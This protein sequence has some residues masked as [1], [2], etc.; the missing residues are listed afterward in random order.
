MK[1]IEETYIEKAIVHDIGV[2][3]PK[4]RRRDCIVLIGGVVGLEFGSWGW[5][6]SR[7]CGEILGQHFDMPRLHEY[8][9]R[10]FLRNIMS[11]ALGI[12]LD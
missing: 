10:C 6:F 5:V 11:Q 3:M 7:S 1:V 4:S 12:W 8:H 2:M 9:T